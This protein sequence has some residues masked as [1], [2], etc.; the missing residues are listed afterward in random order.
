MAKPVGYLRVSSTG[1]AVHG[2]GLNTQ[3]AA[4]QHC[5]KGNGHR[6]VAWYE[7]AGVSGTTDLVT[8]PV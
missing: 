3:K 8:V 2:Y 7:D 5:A 6:V 4:I 1:Q